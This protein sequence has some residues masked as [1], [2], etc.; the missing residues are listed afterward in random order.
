MILQKPGSSVKAR[1][2]R[3]N[4]RFNSDQK[5]LKEEAAFLCYS[6]GQTLLT[7]LHLFHTEFSGL[8]HLN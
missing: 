3:C 2:G 7:F 8:L 4:F 1:E 6:A 5:V